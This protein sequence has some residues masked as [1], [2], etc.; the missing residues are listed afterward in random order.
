[1]PG[2]L[3][4]LPPSEYVPKADGAIDAARGER[5]AVGAERQSAH[6]LLVAGQPPQ[7]FAALDVPQ[8]N[9]VVVTARGECLAV[10]R[11][12]D[13][14]GHVLVPAEDVQG[15]PGGNVPEAHRAVLAS[16]S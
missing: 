4:S 13:R 9:A 10:R 1:M 6:R 16:R 2:Q 14:G 3:S 15:L 7:S 8:E 5:L 11:E 12:G